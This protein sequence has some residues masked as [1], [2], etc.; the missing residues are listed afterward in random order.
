MSNIEFTGLAIVLAL[1][2]IIRQHVLLR[3]AERNYELAHYTIVEIAL[4]NITVEADGYDI[5]FHRV[6]NNSKGE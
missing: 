5:R 3:K 1:A 6:L 4:G 2:F